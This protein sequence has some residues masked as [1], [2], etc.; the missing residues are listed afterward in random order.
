MNIK[1]FFNGTV[2][3]KDLTRFLPLWVIYLILGLL[4]ASRCIGARYDAATQILLNSLRPISILVCVYALVAAQLLFGELFSSKLSIAVHALPVRREGLFIT[5]FT[6]GLIMGIGPM[7]LCAPMAMLCMGRFWYFSLLWVAGIAML[8]LLFFGM[9]VFCMLCSGN[10]I[11]GV[12]LYGL[13]NIIS[14]VALW[15]FDTFFMDRLYGLQM[16]KYMKA[17]FYQFSPVMRCL[18]EYEWITIWHSIDCPVESHNYTYH[19]DCLFEVDPL[20]DIW[21]YLGILAAI[22]F[23]FALVALLLYRIRRLETAEDFLAFQP[24]G[25]AFTALACLCMGALCCRILGRSL[26]G[27]PVGIVIGFF[28]CRMLL[29]RKIKVFRLKN[30][31]KLG[32]LSIAL[33]LSLAGVYQISHHVTNAIPDTDDVISVTVAE[34][35]LDDYDRDS[36]R[37][38]GATTH[39]QYEN[40]THFGLPSAR[41]GYMRLVETCQIADMRQLHQMLMEEGDASKKDYT[42]YDLRYIAIHYLMKDGSTMTRHYYTY[43]ESPVMEQLKN[44]EHTPQYLVGAEFW[45]TVTDNLTA[46]YLNDVKIDDPT[47]LAKLKAALLADAEH[48]QRSTINDYKYRFRLVYTLDEKEHEFPFSI[49]SGI[50]APNILSWIEEYTTQRILSYKID[51]VMLYLGTIYIDGEPHWLEWEEVFLE[52]LYADYKA[53]KLIHDINQP[54]RIELELFDNEGK[55]HYHKLHLQLKGTH[56]LETIN[57]YPAWRE[58]QH[59]KTELKYEQYYAE[60]LF[61]N[62]AESLRPFL[63]FVLLDDRQMIDMIDEE[64]WYQKLLEALCADFQAGKLVLDLDQPVRIELTIDNEYGNSSSYKFHLRLEGTQTLTVIEEYL[65][66]LASI[67]GHI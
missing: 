66:W 37:K 30:W 38:A 58:E 3:K 63:R 52:A 4:V 22:G 43:L 9:A 48:W 53:G 45:D 7:L 17:D 28:V 15:F 51:H 42:G 41:N 31:L 34:R 65:A 36:I 67:S 60:K 11:A 29:E 57:N 39:S 35:E 25:T 14:L 21:G 23:A 33:A 19:T 10:R 6:A 56:V 1:S 16:D 47:L 2:L 8:F 55:R 12:A 20:G 26:I 62:S 5:H 59:A 61:S 13:L 40:N 24:M 49:S 64:D 18:K 46:A 50:D 32:V 27:M 44:Y 54:A